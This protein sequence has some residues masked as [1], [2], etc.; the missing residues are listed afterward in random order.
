MDLWEVFCNP[1]TVRLITYNLFTTVFWLKWPGLCILCN[2][3]PRL[4]SSWSAM[5]SFARLLNPLMLEHKL[6]HLI[7]LHIST[8]GL[9]S[10]VVLST[11]AGK[12]LCYQLPAFLYA[13]RSTCLTLV[14]SPLVSLMEDQVQRQCAHITPFREAGNINMTVKFI[15]RLRIMFRKKSISWNGKMHINIDWKQA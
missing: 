14:I 4:Q 12:S 6:W 7:V 1:S 15:T 10:L 13:Q 11:G 5:M 8:V 9:S 2:A 3:R